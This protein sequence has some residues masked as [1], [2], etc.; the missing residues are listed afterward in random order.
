MH[1]V[2]GRVILFMCGLYVMYLRVLHDVR[3]GGGGYI[4]YVGIIC[5]VSKGIT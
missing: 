4:I 5:H 3:G 2:G 1:D